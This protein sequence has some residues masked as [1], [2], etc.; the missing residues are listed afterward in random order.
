[1]IFP[2]FTPAAFNSW[3]ILRFISLTTFSSR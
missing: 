1:V 2:G 3:R